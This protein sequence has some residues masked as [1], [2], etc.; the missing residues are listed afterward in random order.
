M[1]KKQRIGFFVI[2]TLA[3]FSTFFGSYYLSKRFSTGKNDIIYSTK[4]VNA[5]MVDV[6]TEE[7]VK[8]NTEIIYEIYKNGNK[9]KEEKITAPA[10]YVGKSRSNLIN[11]LDELSDN[12]SVEELQNGLDKLEL[13]SFSGKRVVIRKEYEN[14]L[15]YTYVLYMENGKV[16]VYY[17]DKKTVYSYTDIK[18]E[19]LP[20]SIRKELYNGKEVESTESLYD[21]LETYS[22]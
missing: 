13:I 1:K 15:P 19:D 18:A 11:L 20:E 9:T 22:S 5:A 12:P 21:F 10:E 7:I 17:C 14:P 3:L 6:K 2:L 8:T 16:T 4:E